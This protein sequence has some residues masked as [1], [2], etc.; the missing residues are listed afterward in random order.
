ME[1][2]INAQDQDTALDD[3][4]NSTKESGNNFWK[5]LLRTVLGITI[6][7][8][9]TFG[10]NALIH[11]HRKA[12][13][14][15][16]TAMMVIGNIEAFAENLEQSATRMRWNDTLATYLLAIPKDSLDLFDQDQIY[17]YINNVTAFY[18]L[19][20]DNSAER[21]FTNSVDTWKN[22]GS[23]EFIENVGQCFAD[24]QSI[25]SIYDEFFSTTDRI[26]NRMM[27]NPD[28]YEG[29]SIASKVLHDAEYRIHLMQIHSQGDYYLYLAAY[30]R[31]KNA[32]N[33]EM[34]DV[35]EEELKHFIEERNRKEASSQ[36]APDQ[37]SFRTSSI[38]PDALPDFRD[39]VN[40]QK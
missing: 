22:I 26:M 8:I 3:L 20:H 19:S 14:R 16:M 31:W 25:Q 4:D 11:R 29:N 5:N 39:W 18:S 30:L 10:S 1:D 6:S 28:A 13:D 34:M 15:K 9:L 36:S 35:T 2:I 21:I 24:I 33:M 38:D 12:K 37:N 27:Q 40:R 7:I 23:F 32:K 17:S